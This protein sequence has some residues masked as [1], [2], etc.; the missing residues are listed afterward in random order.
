VEEDE[1]AAASFSHVDAVS[2]RYGFEIFDT[3]ISRIGSHL[4]QYLFGLAHGV[5]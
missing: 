5:E 3:P 4:R 1:M 2:L